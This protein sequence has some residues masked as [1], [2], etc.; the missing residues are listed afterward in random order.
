MQQAQHYEGQGLAQVVIRKQA[1]GTD[2][3]TIDAPT[4]EEI[5]DQ[6]I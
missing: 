2:T 3:V 4:P 1:S 5:W 6:F